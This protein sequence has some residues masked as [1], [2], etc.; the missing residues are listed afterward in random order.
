M[1]S[2]GRVAVSANAW[3]RFAQFAKARDDEREVLKV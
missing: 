2:V 1:K 3:R